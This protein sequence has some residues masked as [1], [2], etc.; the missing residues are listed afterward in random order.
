MTQNGK[1]GLRE[2]LL[3]AR[4]YRMRCYDA[5]LIDLE[6]EDM[7]PMGAP[8]EW[9]V[10]TVVIR[11]LRPVVAALPACRCR[12]SAHRRRGNGRQPPAWTG[13]PAHCKPT[14]H[15]S[16]AERGMD[17]VGGGHPPREPHG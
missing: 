8:L 6:V 1:A 16:A 7:W 2:P 9:T 3:P 11:L 14:D 15:V 12:H 13:S 10:T 5:T 17:R 4:G